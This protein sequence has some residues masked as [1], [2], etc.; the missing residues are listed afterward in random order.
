[1][2]HNCSPKDILALA[3]CSKYFHATLVSNPN[4]QFIWRNA[5]AIALPE[6]IPDP[7]P[8]MSEPGHASLMFDK[9]N[10]EICGFPSKDMYTSFSLK[11]RLCRKLNCWDTFKSMLIQPEFDASSVPTD[12]GF[13]TWLPYAEPQLCRD[14]LFPRE[15]LPG[16]PATRRYYR[17]S[18]LNNALEEYNKARRSQ[19]AMDE[20][21]KSKIQLKTRFSKCMLTCKALYRWKLRWQAARKQTNVL[22]DSIAE[23]VATDEG[24]KKWDLVNATSFKELYDRKNVGLQLISVQDFKAIRSRIETDLIKIEDRRA[25][26]KQQRAYQEC[27]HNIEQ[28][29]DR[30]KGESS[31]FKVLPTLSEFK[32]LPVIELLLSRPTTVTAS[33]L[34]TDP[35]TTLLSDDL[36]KWRKEVQDAFAKKLG[37]LN[38][39]TPSS[40]KLHPVY[41]LSALFTCTGCANRGLREQVL[42]FTNAC[43]HVCPAIS[44][45][46]GTKEVWKIDQFAPQDRARRA[47]ERF[48]SLHGINL[49]LEV[50][51]CAP[52]LVGGHILCLSCSVAIVMNF[53]SMIQHSTR[54]ENMEMTMLTEEEMLETVEVPVEYGLTEK[55]TR[56]GKEAIEERDAVV[57][58]CRHCIDVGRSQSVADSSAV[59]TALSKDKYNRDRGKKGRLMSFNGLRAHVKEK[60]GVRWIADED[61]YRTK[62]VEGSDDCT[63]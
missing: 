37:Y 38:W 59:D 51:L 60:H 63:I 13:S 41:Q 10:C 56:T 49:E 3:R 45:R 22:N 34:Q 20:Y 43:S 23:V 50:S 44:K 42:T 24:W 27:W 17:I 18:D 26:R 36:D 29:Y 39:K 7:L 31:R 52:T 61:Y 5:R 11:A 35:M 62:V 57:Y 15:G 4:S 40:L 1:L 28:C 16:Q 48:A 55:I 58:K 12:I 9:G 53:S 21:T 33:D 25:I 14:E 6:P 30:L 47:V 46:K 19:A 8:G 32:K 2:S 54:H